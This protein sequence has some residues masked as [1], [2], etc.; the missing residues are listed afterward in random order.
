LPA[1]PTRTADNTYTYA[2]NGW[3]KEIK[4]VSGNETYTA[5]YTPTYIEYTVTFVDYDDK[6][7]SEKT[8]H[9]GDTVTIPNDPFRAA[10]D[11]F[12][13]T[14]K[15]WNK[16]IE[17]VTGNETYK[18][19]YKA[20][21]IE[22]TVKF[23]DYNGDEISTLTYHY[24]KTVVIP[25]NP[26]RASDN[27][28]TYTFKEWDKPVTTVSSNVMYTATYK[29][30]YIDYTVTFKNHDGSVI[31]TT[32]YHYG[33]DVAIPADPSRTADNTYT[34]TFKE[35]DKS[36]TSVTGNAEYT[37]TYDSAYI[38]YTV[39]FVDYDDKVLSEAVYH[40][41]DTVTAPANPTREKDGEYTYTFS[42]WNKDITACYGNETYRATYTTDENVYTVTFKNYDNSV[43][44][45]KTYHYEDNVTIPEAP[46]KASDETYYYVF[47]GWDK[48]VVKVTS[49]AVYT[50]VFE[51]K[52]HTW[53]D[54]T[55]E[56]TADHAKV[57]AKRISNNDNTIIQTET[58]TVTTIRTEP[59]CETNGK[60]TY[61]ASFT[62]EAFKTQTYEETIE[63]TG[64]TWTFTGF[65]WTKTD[66]GYTVKAEYK[67]DVCKDTA[68]K[69]AAVTSRTT[70]PTCED[71][72]E[73]VYTASIK[74]AD[75]PDNRSHTEEK[76]ETI[77]A[78]GHKWTY[79]GIT[80]TETDNEYTAYA[81]YKCD[82]CKKTSKVNASVTVSTTSASC[83]EAGEIVYTAKIE[84]KDS[85][86][87]TEHTDTKKV[88]V[89]QV[90]HT[91]TFTGIVWNGEEAEAGYICDKCNETKSV[92]A[93]VTK[94]TKPA[95]CTED[96]VITYTASVEAKDSLDNTEHKNE[97][98]EK[99]DSAKGHSY[100]DPE[101]LWDEGYETAKAKFTCSECNDTLTLDATVEITEKD[102]VITYTA[103]V[104]QGNKD[105]TDTKEVETSLFIPGDI[106]G[107]GSVNNKDVVALFKYVSGG[108]VEVNIVALDVTGD[109]S[110]NNKDVVAL[111]KY[112]SGGDI[113]ISDKPYNPSATVMM[114]ALIPE[115]IKV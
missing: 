88:T 36:V 80:F 77:E 19:E 108:D 102:G 73:I 76:K 8:Y 21:Y 20:T 61:T 94:V 16:D 98:T 85:L 30:T 112:V 31:K 3:D 39:K 17:T 81:S 84:A 62:N 95:T 45:V 10:D 103:T 42:G 11:T 113:E 86:D 24:G 68:S 32:N 91:W 93:M 43:I 5:T 25:D 15:G 114:I 33:D 47:T 34:Y 56:W 106:T 96:G 105:Y 52:E 6:M 107:D 115:K 26:V 75:S 71:E 63:A 60:I 28:Y 90:G 22:Y 99:G 79:T 69:D 92:K 66:N 83:E 29:E 37:A 7:I 38:E 12:T 41:G 4:A 87:N 53:S 27:T 78:K 46:K 104:T 23:V 18:A 100:N 54:P 2:F 59:G 35:W 40:Y 55:Y 57:T 74:S 65:K 97:R 109:G 67:C 64:H 72:G 110:V 82:E 48:E 13:Y 51:A 101:W 9:Y 1:D 70:D 50:A 89:A 44:S 49:D 14:F 58:L 111:F